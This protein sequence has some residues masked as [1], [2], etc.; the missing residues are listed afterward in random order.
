MYIM[1]T[2]IIWKK[3]IDLAY[4]IQGKEVAIVSVFSDNIQHEFT[5][6]WALELEELGNKRITAGTYSR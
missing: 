6:P 2:D 1:I 5:E 3:K 4:L